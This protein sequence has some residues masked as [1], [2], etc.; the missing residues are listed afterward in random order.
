[1]V[2]LG[3]VSDSG[4]SG[5]CPEIYM[6]IHHISDNIGHRQGDLQDSNSHSVEIHETLRYHCLDYQA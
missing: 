4:V 3:E 6:Q 2:L 1:M 5:K